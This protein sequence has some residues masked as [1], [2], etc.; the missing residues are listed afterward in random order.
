MLSPFLI[1]GLGSLDL[2]LRPLT[3]LGS[4]LL[5]AG[6]GSLDFP[7]FGTLNELFD[8]VSVVD[9]FV[10]LGIDENVLSRSRLIGEL[11]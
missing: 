7:Y 2:P 10:E 4:R 6:L 3:G 8:V 1:D 9:G 5:T 11:R